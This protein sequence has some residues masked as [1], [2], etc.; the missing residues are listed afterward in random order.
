M[1]ADAGTTAPRHSHQLSRKPMRNRAYIVGIRPLD[2]E[3][4][5][6]LLIRV[7]ILRRESSV[8][9]R[10]RLPVV[11]TRR[12]GSETLLHLRPFIALTHT[13]TSISSPTTKPSSSSSLRET[14]S[15]LPPTSATATTYHPSSSA[16]TPH[17]ARHIPHPSHPIKPTP[18]PQPPP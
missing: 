7:L 17:H 14:A 18:P 11:A 6:D 2:N 12:V 5:S 8:R 13:T 4:P 1:I 9:H 15:T 3:T 16:S 10:R